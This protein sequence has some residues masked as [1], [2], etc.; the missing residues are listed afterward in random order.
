[1]ISGKSRAHALPPRRPPAREQAGPGYQIRHHW[2]AAVRGSGIRSG[3]IASI[4][5]KV[6]RSLAVISRPS[7]RVRHG[8]VSVFG[9][10]LQE[11]LDERA[12][13]RDLEAT[14]PGVVKGAFDEY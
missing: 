13:R 8:E 6:P 1:M 7:G 5:A 3:E 10:M 2:P 9:V 14:L 4:V 12:D 11:G